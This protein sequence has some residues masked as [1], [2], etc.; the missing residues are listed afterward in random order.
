MDGIILT[1]GKQAVEAGVQ[2]K[3]K[4]DFT[5]CESGL[6][7]PASAEFTWKLR[8]PADADWSVNVLSNSMAVTNYLGSGLNELS[9]GRR[10]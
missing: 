1:I 9:F 3:Y 2:F 10:N 7:P 6:L 5:N 4:S 8:K